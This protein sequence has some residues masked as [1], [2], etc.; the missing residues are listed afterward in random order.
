MLTDT[1][2]QGPLRGVK[3]LEF[4]GLGPAPFCAMLL[5]DLGAEVVRID[6]PH[7]GGGGP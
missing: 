3:V 2:A 7:A 5:S 4:V 6:R 1:K